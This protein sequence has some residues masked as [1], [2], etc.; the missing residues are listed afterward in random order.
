VEEGSIYKLAGV[1]V[2]GSPVDSRTFA[3][4]QSF[5]P[6]EVFQL[7]QI[8][9]GREQVMRSLRR[10]GYMTAKSEWRRNIDEA[11]RTVALA[12]AIEPGPQFLFGKL[13]I[14]GLD[15]E[16]EPAIRKLWTLKPGQPFNADYPDY[17]LQRVREDGVLD[18][19]GATKSQLRLDEAS[20]TVDVTLFFQ[21]EKPAG[22]RRRAPRR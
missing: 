13:D 6:G 5:K 20:R 4:I 16:T 8:E 14:Q 18:N 21:G 7:P 15:I 17:F 10:A 9:E 2:E 19:L 3:K 1:V 11:A 12:L 22:I